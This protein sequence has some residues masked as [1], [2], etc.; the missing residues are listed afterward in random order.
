MPFGAFA[1]SALRTPDLLTLHPIV[2]QVPTLLLFP[3]L[4]VLLTSL[5]L[6][7]VIFASAKLAAAPMCTGDPLELLCWFFTC[8][9]TG[10]QVT[11]HI[12]SFYTFTSIRLHIDAQACPTDYLE[13]VHL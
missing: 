4:E 10:H 1:S 3:N 7:G 5:M 8:L 11:H 12:T 9:Y 13:R 2:P 6:P